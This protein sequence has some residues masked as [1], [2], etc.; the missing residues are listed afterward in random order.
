MEQ[1]KVITQ[2]LIK[3]FQKLN[4]FVSKDIVLYI[5]LPKLNELD[6]MIF[7]VACFPNLITELTKNT[8][9]LNQCAKYGHLELL[10]WTR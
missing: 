5:L 7:T 9:I 3:I 4:T 2:I 8:K 6:I 10:K 1:Q